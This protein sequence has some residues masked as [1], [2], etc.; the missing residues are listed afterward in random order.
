[1]IK[2]NQ[3]SKSKSPFLSIRP[4]FYFTSYF[5]AE[6]KII[7][8]YLN[9]LKNWILN[10]ILCSKI[11]FLLSSLI[12]IW[13]FIRNVWVPQYWPNCDTTQFKS[14]FFTPT[15]LLLSIILVRFSIEFIAC[16]VN[17]QR[18]CTLQKSGVEIGLSD[19]PK[20][21]GG[22]PWPTLPPSFG[23]SDHYCCTR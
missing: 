23:I 19:L 22:G 5:Y 1:M 17:L 18:L 21:G 16:Q 2:K 9:T 14:I 6:K 8:W 3:N 20:I 15:L 13:I 11:F 12:R 10:T 4:A 7:G